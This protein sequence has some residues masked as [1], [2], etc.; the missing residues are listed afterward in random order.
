MAMPSTDARA[1]PATARARRWSL[2]AAIASVTVF[3]LSI[4][5]AGPLLSLLLEARGTDVTL[6]GLNAGATF[7]GVIVGPLLAP[8]LVR[9]FG[10]RNF[11]LVCFGLD[12][13]LFL[14]MK[15]LD[16]L[17]AWFVLRPVGAAV[18]SSIFTTGEAWINQLAGDAG[19]G[20]IIGFY[21]AALSAGFGAG[22]LILSV[23]GIDGWLPFLANA[24]IAA[25]ATLPLF[26]LGGTPHGFDGE[27]GAGPLRMFVRAPI[28]VATVAVFGLYESALMS[29]LPIWGVRSGMTERWAAATLSAVHFGAITLQ[30]PIGWLSDRASRPAALLLCGAVGLAGAI[31]LVGM[32]ALSPALFGLLFVWGGVA[33]GIYPVALSMAGDRFRGGELVSVNA[34]MIMAYGLGGL[35]GPAMGGVAMD[36]DDRQGLP[37]LFA[38][39][40]AGLLAVSLLAA[41]VRRRHARA[42]R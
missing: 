33:S 17:A 36:L 42:V 23:T 7:I 28:I 41:S 39:L 6:N 22:P 31:A 3:G 40:F 21:A 12:I 38:G 4:G 34:A 35:A 25:V 5:Q 32:P 10:I 13:A 20:R 26:G 24:A 15:P 11:L 37:W 16:G 27:R 9:R 1:L 18:G 29:L 19:R 14:A 30:V 8:R 2:A